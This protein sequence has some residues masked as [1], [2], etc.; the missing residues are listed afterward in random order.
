MPMTRL[1]NAL[2]GVAG[3][4][5]GKFTVVGMAKIISF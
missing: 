4:I 5:A 1:V 2:L 3:V